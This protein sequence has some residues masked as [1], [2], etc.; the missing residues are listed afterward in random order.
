MFL[1][2][3]IWASAVI[4]LIAWLIPA[5]SF[6]V[7]RD[8][9]A[10]NSL[11][12]QVH[13]EYL[14]DTSEGTNS[15]K[16]VS[17][18]FLQ[19]YTLDM[20]GYY[21][22]R[23]L[24]TYDA[25][26]GY[27][28]KQNSTNTTDTDTGI[29]NYYLSTTLLPL[30]YIPLTLYANR[31]SRTIET[32]SSDSSSTRT[33]FGLSWS[34]FFRRLPETTLKARRIQTDNSDGSN[35]TTDTYQVGMKK[36]IGP[37]RNRLNY[38]LSNSSLDEK[39]ASQYALN[40]NNDTDISK[41]TIFRLGATRGVTE[42]W[43]NPASTVTG[44]SLSLESAPS[45]EFTQRHSYGYF[46]NETDGDSQTGSVYS[47]QMSYDFSTRLASSLSLN[48][49][50]NLSD[51]GTFTAE[52]ESF[53][54]T[55][56]VN[57][58]LTS[59]VGLSQLVSYSRTETN[60]TDPAANVSDLESLNTLTSASYIKN[61]NWAILGSSAGLGYAD[62]KSQD[63]RGQAVTQNYTL[64]LTNIDLNKYVGASTSFTHSSATTISGD[65]IDS[66]NQTYNLDMYNKMWRKY[67]ESTASYTRSVY[68]TYLTDFRSKKDTFQFRANSK[69]F[70]GTKLYANARYQNSSQGLVGDS[71]NTSVEFGGNHQRNLYRGKLALSLSYTIS[72]STYDGGS[73]SYTTLRYSLGYNR[74]LFKRIGWAA[75]FD[76]FEE[77]ASNSFTN[78]TTI[79][80]NL[81]YAL[82]SWLL[83]LEHNYTI[84]EDLNNEVVRTSIM[85]R[86]SRAFIRI[87]R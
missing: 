48:V 21:A 44:L 32:S 53:S 12:G 29:H 85:L 67:V 64:S 61:L 37:T 47:G 18:S 2:K 31:Q 75:L 83:S 19:R 55:A 23:R 40:F 38:S 9:Y 66:T 82:R 78:Q 33:E 14:R 39:S 17:D 86:A 50:N 11:I 25:G 7:E 80:N 28:N 56:N 87:W 52:S 65:N 70:K 34:L 13:L 54:T 58:R 51:S 42:S 57:Y 36:D 74:T 20:R 77:D 71:Q 81:S 46:S 15:K 6:S 8:P 30:S 60:S 41:S 72:D 3:R 1:L 43:D 76:R 79:S 24:L 27:I 73:N 35:Q 26:W 22:S 68:E 62:E 10:V 16:T 4:A 59:A 49:N 69:Y 45:K 63:A 84:L 5:Q